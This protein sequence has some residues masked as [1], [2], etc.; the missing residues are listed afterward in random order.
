M[1]R[2]AVVGLWV[3][4][5]TLVGGYF[6]TQWQPKTND[7]HAAAEK[8]ATFKI[9][10]LSIP[11]LKNGDVSG[12]VVCRFTYLASADV[13]KGLAVKPDAFVMDAAF[14][15]IYTGRDMDITKLNKDSWNDV[16]K[17]VKAAVNVRYGRDV[18]QDLVLDEF[19]YVTAEMAR[20]G[21]ESNA[22]AEAVKKGKH[23]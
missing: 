17:S 5:V 4:A 11:I 21:G 19:T 16:A 13:I 23:H 3:C 1:I 20:S 22:N 6:G 8:V 9:K 18:L 12:Y 15:S 7:S 14:S 10:P 2:T